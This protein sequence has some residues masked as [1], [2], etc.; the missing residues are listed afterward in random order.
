MNIFL[1]FPNFDKKFTIVKTVN[2][3]K[4][5]KP[6]RFT[7]VKLIYNIIVSFSH[8]AIAIRSIDRAI[9]NQAKINIHF[10]IN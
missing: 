4:N 10:S 5:S 6:H 1:L 7:M 2:I 3:T 9:T 8:I